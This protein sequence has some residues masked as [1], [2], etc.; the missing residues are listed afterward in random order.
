MSSTSSV[1]AIANTPSLNASIRPVPQRFPIARPFGA[2]KA[3]PTTGLARVGVEVL[4]DELDRG[5]A[6][7]HGGRDALHRAVTDVA[8]GENAGQ[9][10]LEK[11]RWA[12]ERPSV[13]RQVG[14][15]ED[16]PALVANHGIAEPV[17]SRLCP[18]HHE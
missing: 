16:E 1:I 13:G 10:R 17:G 2:A 11:E 12:I 6:F 7:A 8:G 4:V 14:T 15:G 3:T 5:R 9:A 18:D